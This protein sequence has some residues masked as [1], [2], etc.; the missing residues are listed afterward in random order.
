MTC[1]RPCGKLVAEAGIEALESLPRGLP[2]GIHLCS[3][4]VHESRPVL[5]KTHLIRKPFLPIREFLGSRHYQGVC[6]QLQGCWS[7]LPARRSS[8]HALLLWVRM[9]VSFPAMVAGQS[10]SRWQKHIYTP[11]TCPEQIR[12]GGMETG[13]EK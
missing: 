3:K 6:L 10:C 9:L 13:G 5:V 12:W 11:P 7:P 2:S 1:Q 8:G 4:S